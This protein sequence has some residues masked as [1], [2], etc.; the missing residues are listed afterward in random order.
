MNSKKKQKKKQLG[1]K[2][3]EL[4]EH[5]QYKP[6]T[7]LQ[8]QELKQKL[9]GVHNCHLLSTGVPRVNQDNDHSLWLFMKFESFCIIFRKTLAM[10]VHASDPW[11][12]I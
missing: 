9:S 5:A 2:G 3:T 11:T 12:W 6:D 7:Q 8:S 1:N 10:P 4:N